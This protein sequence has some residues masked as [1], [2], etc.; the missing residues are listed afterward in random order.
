MTVVHPPAD[1][2]SRRSQLRRLESLA[3]VPAGIARTC[4]RCQQSYTPQLRGHFLCLACNAA[5]IADGVPR[6]ERLRYLLT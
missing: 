3:R 2:D 5:L 4:P 1:P 6:R